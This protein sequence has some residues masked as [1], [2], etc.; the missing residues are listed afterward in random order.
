MEYE[1][2]LDLK[3]VNAQ[4]FFTT[5][6][7]NS[8]KYID[9][10]IWYGLEKDMV[11]AWLKNFSTQKQQY[12][13]ACLLDSIIYRSNEQ[14]ESLLEHLLDVT[15]PNLIYQVDSSKGLNFNPDI[16]GKRNCGLKFTAPVDHGTSSGNMILRKLKTNFRVRESNI[17]AFDELKDPKHQNHEIIIVV[18]DFTGS[19]NQ[20]CDYINDHGLQRTINSTPTIFIPLI[21]CEQGIKKISNQFKNIR[22]APVETINNDQNF[23]NKFKGQTGKKYYEYFMKSKL[24]NNIPFD[25]FLFGYDQMGLCV[26]FEEKTPNNT[27]P[28]FN[29]KSSKHNWF[30]MS[31]VT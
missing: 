29:W 3:K 17:I 24:K 27:L 1:Y 2:E 22:V 20:F 13:A 16:F 25:K 19:G 23:F 26:L 30:Q 21:G 4:E 9:N 28:I 6:T 5:I 12:L 11:S 8:M 15:L 7:S 10:K 18:D 14:M 31:N